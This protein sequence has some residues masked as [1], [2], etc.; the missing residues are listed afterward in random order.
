MSN[1][2]KL[3]IWGIALFIILV[4]VIAFFPIVIV[5][6]G[7]RGVVFNNSTG[8]ENRVLSE[9]THF[10]IPFV[11]QVINMPVR[12]Q[13]TTFEEN[14]GTQDSQSID[15]KL[16]V[17]WH[18]DPAYVSWIYNNIGNNDVVISNVLTNNTQDAVKAAISKHAALDIQKNRDVVSASAE[19]ILQQKLLRYHLVVDNLSLTNINFSAQFNTAVEEAQAAQQEA[20]KAQ[21]QVITAQNNAQSAIAE[22]EGRAKAQQVV[23]QT[24]TPQILEQLWIAKWDGKLPTYST[25]QLPFPVFTPGQ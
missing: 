4:I 25:S 17:N 19:S 7:E 16:T 12:T 6:A 23:Q 24:L 15:V 5:G 20:K 8:I 10:R 14:A 22:A 21:Y 1:Q 9:G 11:E 3:T 13:A 18:L 2:A